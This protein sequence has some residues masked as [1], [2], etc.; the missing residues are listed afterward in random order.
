M[1]EM[2]QLSFY[3]TNLFNFRVETPTFLT[4][5]LTKNKQQVMATLKSEKTVLEVKV[6]LMKL[7]VMDMSWQK[8]EN[9]NKFIYSVFLEIYDNNESEALLFMKHTLDSQTLSAILDD[10]RPGFI[11][12]HSPHW[13][14]TFLNPQ[15]E[16]KTKSL[17]KC[18]LQI[19][20]KNVLYNFDFVQD[21][22]LLWFLWKLVSPTSVLTHWTNFSSQIVALL[23]IA[24]VLPVLWTAVSLTINEPSLIHG[25][26]YN[27]TAPLP[28]VFILL[29]SPLIPT[30][31]I[32]IIVIEEE[33]IKNMLMAD[34]TKK[35]ILTIRDRHNYLQNVKKALLKFKRNEYCL[36]V[37]IQTTIRLLMLCIFISE[38]STTNVLQTV[39][40]SEGLHSMFIMATIWS[41]ASIFRTFVNIKLEKKSGPIPIAGQLLFP[42][43]AVFSIGP[44]LACIILYFTPYLGLF[45]IHKHA[46]AESM[47]Y[48]P[49]AFTADHSWTEDNYEYLYMDKIRS[50]PYKSLFRSDYTTDPPTTVDYTEYTAGITLK[51]AYITL[52]AIIII[53]VLIIGIFKW[54]LSDDFKCAPTSQKI[55]HCLET[56]NISD[57]YQDW[58]EG[59]EHHT[60]ATYRDRFARVKREMLWAIFLHWALNMF[61][62]LPLFVT[63]NSP[64]Y[65]LS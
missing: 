28:Q 26:G 32:H 42:F 17:T 6:S 47:S 27:M 19:V 51:V 5:I 33:N 61:L 58:D 37:F 30:T 3:R 48:T 53:N 25:Y 10:V 15:Y 14:K 46:L 36:E 8:R 20:L 62:L 44:R 54:W 41:L 24:V 9:L 34:L 40:L 13:L 59:E 1:R 50:I 64:F 38:T 18:A 55:R 43:R 12:M 16:S 22:T 39:F 7:Q 21:V 57:V 11:K 4:D 52:I 60:I 31:L 35:S 56:L 2:V 23:L 65:L 29:I 49:Q 63:G 45:N